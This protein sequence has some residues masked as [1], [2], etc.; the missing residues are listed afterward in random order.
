MTPNEPVAG[1]NVGEGDR[2]ALFVAAALSAGLVAIDTTV[3]M[4]ARGS[5][6]VASAVV[7][8]TMEA[9][10][11]AVAVASTPVTS[12]P[13]AVTAVVSTADAVPATETGKPV[14]ALCAPV[15]VMNT[16][17]STVTVST[18]SG[19]TDDGGASVEKVAG[20][21]VAAAEAVPLTSVGI[22]VPAI[23]VATATLDVTGRAVEADGKA[24]EGK[25]STEA[26]L[27]VGITGETG[28]A[29]ASPELENKDVEEMA[30]VAVTMAGGGAAV[31]NAGV[32]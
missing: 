21:E 6:D 9:V 16:V 3:G 20:T 14:V 24:S 30:S 26:S 7:V 18:P 25:E 19:P 31:V 28:A 12:T 27:A 8:A 17:D 11:K 32:A 13:V 5:E 4:E 29:E 15:T 10:P 1:V 22:A 2:A 23:P